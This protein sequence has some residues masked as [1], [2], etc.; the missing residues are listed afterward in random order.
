MAST[1]L[2]RTS[3]AGACPKT[4]LILKR[5]MV[6]SPAKRPPYGIAKYKVGGYSGGPDTSH[7]IVCQSRNELP[8]AKPEL[9]AI[10]S[11]ASWRWDSSR[12]HTRPTTERSTLERYWLSE[13]I[14]RAFHSRPTRCQSGCATRLLIA[15]RKV[16]WCN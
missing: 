2:L 3:N 7:K 10:T 12:A 9:S 4:L 13:V 16:S 1:W 5:T 15:S 11:G 14:P 8:L 6:F